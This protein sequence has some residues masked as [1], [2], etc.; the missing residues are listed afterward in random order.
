MEYGRGSSL[1]R[2]SE[3]PCCVLILVLMEYGLEHNEQQSLDVFSY[4]VLILV[5]MEYGLGQPLK[6]KY[7]LNDEQS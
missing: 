7:W 1:S 2:N 5:L 3:A 6:E 4:A